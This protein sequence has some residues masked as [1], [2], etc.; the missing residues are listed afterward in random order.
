MMSS[1]ELVLTWS[2]GF[3]SLSPD[4]PPCPG[5]KSIDWYETHPRCTAWIEEWGLQAAELGWGTLRLFGVHPTHGILHGDY[6]GALLPLT[7]DVR[8]VNADFMRIGNGRA[9][10]LTPVK[11]P[12]VPIWDFGKSL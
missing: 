1:L 10:R 2:R 11:S 6:T 8:E 5:L 7:R 4:Q 12:G 9:W 3:A